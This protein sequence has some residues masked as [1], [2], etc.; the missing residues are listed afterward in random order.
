MACRKVFVNS[1]STNIIFRWDY[2]TA[3]HTFRK[4]PVRD[5]ILVENQKNH[6]N[7]NAIGM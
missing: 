3:S 4:S 2:S 5:E 6:G 7:E 1:V